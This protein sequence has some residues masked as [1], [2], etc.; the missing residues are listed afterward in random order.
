MGLLDKDAKPTLVGAEDNEVFEQPDNGYADDMESG[1]HSEELIQQKAELFSA[2]NIVLGLQF[3]PGKIR[4]LLQDFLPKRLRSRAMHMTIY[5][6]GWIPQQIPIATSGCSE[7]LGGIYD[8]DNSY[9]SAMAHMLETA[10]LHSNAIQ[11]THFSAD[12]KILVATTS[13]VNKLRYKWETS[14]LDHED[15]IRIDSVLDAGYVQA[16]KNMQ[17][18][19]RKLL[20]VP[21]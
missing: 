16:T 14:S 7:Y 9:S 12:S 19:P 20:H 2:F 11:H 17:S 8:L 4:R 1:S 18:H 15:A 6:T 5:S 13:T 21:R 10:K 3:S